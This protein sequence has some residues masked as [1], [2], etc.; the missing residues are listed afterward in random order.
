[1]PTRKDAQ[2][3]WHVEVCVRSRRI[4]RR[5]PPGASARDAKR[6]ETE[7]NRALNAGPRVP[8]VPGNP[9]LSELVGDYTERHAHQLRSP[10]TAQHHGYRLEKWIEGKRASEAKVV[11][12]TFIRELSPKY[13]AGTIN[14]SIGVLKKALSLAWAEER[15]TADYGAQIRRLPE[16]NIRMTALSI[17]EVRKLASHASENV[18]AAIWIALFTGCRRGEICKIKATDVGEHKIRLPAG[19]TKTLRHREVPITPALRPWL[20]F[21]PMPITALGISSGFHNART[22]AGMPKVTFHD[23]RRSCA[24]LMIGAGV[25]LYVVSKLLGHTNVAVTQTRYAHLHTDR[26]AEGLAL[27]FSTGN[28]HRPS[29]SG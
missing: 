7:L 10:K 28:L 16:R 22:A 24:T 6:L 18:A 12:A 1:M 4:H 26:I 2:G 5:C 11:A 14:R 29:V 3:R 9:L 15:T 8:V 25:D 21:L 27:T 13:T 23:L 19:N 17:E 20:K